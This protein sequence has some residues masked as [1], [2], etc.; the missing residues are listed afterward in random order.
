MKKYYYDLHIHSALSPCGDNESTPANIVGMAYISGLDIIALTDHNTT[1]NCPAFLKAS[2]AYPI[3]AL[4][5]MELTTSE[6][7][8]VVCLFERIE[9]AMKFGDYVDSRRIKIKNK[10]EIF[11]EQ[12]IFDEND[13]V[14]GA[15]ENLLINATLIS[16]EELPKLVEDFGGIC[17]PAH[18][19]KASNGLIAILG[20]IPDTK[21][22]SCYELRS[23]DCAEALAEKY[24]I[25]KDRL[26][27][28]SDSHSL[29]EVSDKE[30]YFELEECADKKEIIS[31]LFRW[32]RAK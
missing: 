30:N 16:I 23:K 7:I 29:G 14:I 10:P 4:P 3:V 15:E 12:Y 32:L 25:S 28:D 6:D 9:D 27:F 22:F 24:G 26:I 2:E 13:T 8:H 5:G 18:I 1:K 11:G 20:T 17:F 31:E 21:Q 19:D